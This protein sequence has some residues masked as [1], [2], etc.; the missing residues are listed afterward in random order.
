MIH[1]GEYSEPPIAYRWVRM[2]NFRF[3]TTIRKLDD[4]LVVG[5]KS[6]LS[7]EQIA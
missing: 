1:A 3:A 6:P 7:R 2:G 4:L 5:E